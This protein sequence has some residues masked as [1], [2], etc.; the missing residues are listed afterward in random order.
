MKGQK[1]QTSSLDEAINDYLF[2]LRAEVGA[3]KNTLEAYTRDLKEYASFLKERFIVDLEDISSD[4]VASF[5]T[6][7]TKAGA[8]PS[9]VKRK[10]SAVKGFH[11]FLVREDICESSP[12]ASVPF[13]KAPEMLPDVLSVEEV[14]RMLDSIICINARSCRDRALLEVLYGCGL[15][16]S[17]VCALDISDVHLDEG[18]LCVIGKGDKQRFVPISGQAKKALFLYLEN[19]RAELSLANKKATSSCDNAV[20]LNARGGRLT[21]QG[22]FN[23]VKKAASSCGIEDVHPHTLRHSF[24][25][26]MLEGGADLRVIQQILGH[27]DIST[28]QIYTHVDRHHLKEEYLVAHPRAR[29][30]SASLKRK[31]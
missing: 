7:L 5:S 21:R 25:T 12:A 13:P 16:V 11:K 17:E 22:V 24:A 1:N 23:I 8:A 6:M 10:L 19:S 31:S 26:H 30:T 28:T 9:T 20:F 15:R 18:F 2:S 29:K 4:D 14:C 3:S 27:S